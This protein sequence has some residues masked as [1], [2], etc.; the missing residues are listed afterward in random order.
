[1][2]CGKDAVADETHDAVA[3]EKHDAVTDGDRC[4]VKRSQLAPIQTDVR[5]KT[6]SGDTGRV[7]M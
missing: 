5:D 7:Q 6:L 3:D 2:A 1:M 4:D